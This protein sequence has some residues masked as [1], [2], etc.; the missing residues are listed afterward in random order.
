[1]RQTDILHLME[2][3]CA[4]YGIKMNKSDISQYLSGKVEPSSEKLLLLSMALNVSAVWLMGFD[5]AMA[6]SYPVRIVQ[7]YSKLNDIGKHEA[8]KRVKELSYVP[9]YTWDPDFTK[10]TPEERSRLEEVENGEYADS[11]NIDWNN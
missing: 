10:L 8:E 5:V 1:M 7:C 6:D 4:E 11:E 3:F 9:R 2:P